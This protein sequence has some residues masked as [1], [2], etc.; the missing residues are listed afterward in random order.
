MNAA[1]KVAIATLSSILLLG[2]SASLVAGAQSY[3]KAT[4]GAAAKKTAEATMAIPAE[5]KKF[6]EQEIQRVKE[7]TQESGDMYV[8]YHKYPKLNSGFDISFWGGIHEFTTYEDY[9]K[10]ASTLK[11]SILQ[12]PANLPKGYKFLSAVIEAPTKGKFVDEVRAEGKKSGK[13]IYMKKIDWKE[14]ATIRLKYT[15]GKDTLGFSKY[16]VDSEGSKKKGFFD[17]ELPKNV[18]P[19]YVFW[20]DGGKFEY[21]ISTSS[22]DM[23][24]K[25]KIEMLKAA[26]KK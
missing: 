22:L 3:E 10:K 7:L 26:V 25:E 24:R 5:E 6:I 17:D 1:T 14:A 18:F 20:N 23:S 21:S 15:N 12:Q 19:K 16:T 2:S 11:G 4:Q 9:L 13:P 8:L